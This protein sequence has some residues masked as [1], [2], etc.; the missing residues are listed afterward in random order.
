M[1][2]WFSVGQY[3]NLITSGIL[4]LLGIN[5]IAGFASMQM[6]DQ[7][8]GQSKTTSFLDDILND[9]D[10]PKLHRFQAVAWTVILGVIFVWNVFWNFSFVEFDTNLLLLIG[11][12]QSMYVGFKYQEKPGV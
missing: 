2:I 3:F 4:V 11:I 7:K 8:E 10:G 12:A 5:G 9:G 6:D 1:F